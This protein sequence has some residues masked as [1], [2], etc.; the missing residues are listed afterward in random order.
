MSIP[1]LKRK[2]QDAKNSLREGLCS[3]KFYWTGK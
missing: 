1:E 3:L 2:L